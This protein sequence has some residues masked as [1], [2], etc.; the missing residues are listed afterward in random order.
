[1]PNIGIDKKTFEKIAREYYRRWRIRLYAVN[2]AGQTVF[3]KGCCKDDGTEKCLLAR[4]HAITE[5]T[6]WGEPTVDLCP[7]HRMI[8]AIP[9]TYNNTV[10]GGLVAGAAE[11]DIFPNRDGTA[12]LDTRKACLELRQLAEREN[13]VNTALLAARREHHHRERK[14]AEAIHELKLL[15]PTDIRRMYL[16]EEPSLLAAIRRDDRGEARNILNSILAAIHYRA[17]KRIPLIK[18]F[19]MELVVTM[20]RT[21]VEAGGNAEEL[22]GTNFASLQKLSQIQT[23][24][25][26]APWLREILERIMDAI[27]KHHRQPHAV[28]ADAALKYMSENYQQNISRDDVAEAIGLSP[29][30]FSRLVK[31]QLGRNFTELLNQIRVNRSAELLVRSDKPLAMIGM[32]VGFHDQS[33][34][35][36][37]FHRY[38]KRTP[39]QY[40]QRQILQEL[41]IDAPATKSAV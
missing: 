28:L 14:W 6:R 38:M 15:P 34:F 35:T 25:Q 31:K 37:V 5:A 10:L 7:K 19:F 36:K 24:E 17:D 33:Y 23:Q 29:S 12:T 40:R 9:L 13:L 11:R 39:R 41:P 18:S 32:E 1:M 20:C 26:L 30:H 27:R 3:G 8:W 16:R 21:A 4:T 2:P 22:F